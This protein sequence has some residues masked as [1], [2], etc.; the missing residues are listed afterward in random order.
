METYK[1]V[2]N[3]EGIYEVSELGNVK[4]LKYGVERQVK[5]ILSTSGYL[6][7]NLYKDNKTKARTIHQLVAEAFLDHTPNGHERVVNHIDFNKLNNKVVNLEIIANRDN[8]NKKHLK[9]SSKYTGVDLRS[10]GK[11]RAQIYTDGKQRYIGS[12]KEE[13][14]AHNAYQNELSKIN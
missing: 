2:K 4:S 9:S 3:H 12:F 11:W 8:S 14:D 13:I 6:F 10:N 7:V 5:P 1:A